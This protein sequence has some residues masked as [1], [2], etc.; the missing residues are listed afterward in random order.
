MVE[1]SVAVRAAKP[2]VGPAV[3]AV[4]GCMAEVK[5]KAILAGRAVCMLAAMAVAMVAARELAMVAAM[6][7]DVEM[8]SRA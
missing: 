2:V 1:A 4:H 8:D 7:T 3:V 5:A 6:G